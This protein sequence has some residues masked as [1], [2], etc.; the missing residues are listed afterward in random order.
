MKLENNSGV[1][2]P[3]AIMYFLKD[4][5]FFEDFCELSVL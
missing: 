2:Y 4:A 5:A 1:Q 3:N